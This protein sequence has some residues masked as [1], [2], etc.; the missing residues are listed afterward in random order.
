ML[1][2]PLNVVMVAVKSIDTD[3][4]LHVRDSIPS[5]SNI[6]RMKDALAAGA[7]LPPIVVWKERMLCIDGVDRCKAYQK[8]YGDDYKIPVLYKHYKTELDALYDFAALNS[9]HGL[10]LDTH[11]RVLLAIKVKKLGG[12]LTDLAGHLHVT[13]DSFVAAIEKRMATSD[14]G[15]PVALK[16]SLKHMKDKILTSGQVEANK[17]LTGWALTG[18]A[19]QLITLLRNKMA[20]LTNENFTAALY[21][22]RGEIEKFFKE[23]PQILARSIET[24]R[25]RKKAQGSA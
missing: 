25:L 12:S 23:H 21:E 8:L 2:L 11:E 20:D 22:L 14:D 13:P 15:E 4:D 6:A 10:P 1:R 24:T 7:T 17:H 9:T 18:N 16:T 19:T 3:H 5:G